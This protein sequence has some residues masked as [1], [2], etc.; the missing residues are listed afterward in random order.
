[1]ALVKLGGLAQDVRGSLNGSVFSRN[2]GGAYVRT[3]VSP[4]QPISR[5]SGLVRCIFPAIS[6]RW[7]T[8]LTDIQRTDWE[9]WA[10]TH[11]IANV[12]GDAIILSGVA[13][14]MRVVAYL[15]MCGCGYLSAAP[16]TFA[17]ADPGTPVVVATALAGVLTLSVAA[18]RAL[19]ADEGNMV[20]L[21]KPLS[22]S[23]APQQGDYKLLNLA[24][25]TS[26]QNADPLGSQVLIRIPNTTWVVGQRIGVYFAVINKVTGAVSAWVPVVHV[27]TAP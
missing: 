15:R 18:G 5:W 26:F 19:T 10:A 3:K 14:Y 8:V 9:A 27:I 17:V 21:T 6:A 20:Y 16:T 7:S 11:P 23:R 24:S 4:V 1:M 12:F 2:R 22:G 25:L 13:C